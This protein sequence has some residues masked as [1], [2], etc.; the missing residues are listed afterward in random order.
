MEIMNF[1]LSAILKDSGA[2]ANNKRDWSWLS[3][4]SKQIYDNADD[5]VKNYGNAADDYVNYLTFDLPG[6]P[7][8]RPMDKTSIKLT[9]C[10]GQLWSLSIIIIDI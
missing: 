1:F 8:L 4:N 2:R 9:L 7:F 5:Y 3:W 10:G 6:L